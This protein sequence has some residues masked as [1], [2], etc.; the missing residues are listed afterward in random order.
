M[1]ALGEASCYVCV[2]SPC[3]YI[4]TTCSI[5]LNALLELSRPIYDGKLIIRVEQNNA[6]V[7]WLYYPENFIIPEDGDT[8][9]WIIDACL[10]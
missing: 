8:G 9:H 4:A 5:I 6:N 2:V 7:E 1:N 10:K 3:Y